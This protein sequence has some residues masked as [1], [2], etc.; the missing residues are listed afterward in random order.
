MYFFTFLLPALASALPQLTERAADVNLSYQY[1]F[2][3]NFNHTGVPDTVHFNKKQFDQ[4]SALVPVTVGNGG[5]IVVTGAPNVTEIAHYNDTHV[6]VGDS[7]EKAAES[8][9]RCPTCIAACTILG[10]LGPEAIIPCSKSTLEV[11]DR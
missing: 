7:V 1:C 2:P 4:F 5:E 3:S 6:N 8:D 10:F 11:L 9:P